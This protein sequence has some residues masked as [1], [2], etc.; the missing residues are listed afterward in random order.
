MKD[1]EQVLLKVRSVIGAKVT[2]DGE[3]N[4]EEIHIVANL[5][6]STTQIMRDVESIMLSEYNRTLDN[7][8]ISIVQVKSEWNAEEQDVRLKLKTIE[9]SNDGSSIDVSIILEK[10]EG[11]YACTQSGIKTETNVMRLA[12]TAT[13]R[14]IEEYL[15]IKE[16]FVF[17]ECREMFLSGMRII[18]VTIASIANEQEELFIGTA[19]VKSD[20]NEAVARATLDALNRQVHYLES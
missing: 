20:L 10:N 8:K 19:Q 14:A 4:I 11:Q 2:V 5:R 7:R 1:M 9:Y 6:R 15:G 13:L 18:I 3:G 16:V 12:G 17:E